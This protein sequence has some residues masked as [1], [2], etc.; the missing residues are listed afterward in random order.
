MLYIA[1]IYVY[2]VYLVM[3][4]KYQINIHMYYV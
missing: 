1:V 3:T 4:E 2:K